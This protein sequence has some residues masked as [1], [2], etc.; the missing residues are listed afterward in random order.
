MI[1]EGPGATRHDDPLADWRL[2]REPFYMPV[3]DEVA[4]FD[5]AHR[6]RLPVLLKGPTGCG[7]TRFVEHM[8]WRLGK[9]LVTVACHDDLAASDLTGRWLLD[10]EGTRW[11]D[12]PLTLA[13]RHG[14]LCYLD[15]IVEARS[16]TTVVLHPL[17]DSRRLLPLEKRDEL[18]RAHADFQLV[19]SYNPGYRGISKSLKPSTRQRFM[20]L[21]FGYPDAEQEAAIVAREA[22]V[23]PGLALRLVVLAGRTRRLVDEGLD[24]GASTRMVIHAANL[25]RQGLGHR[26]ACRQAMV[27]PLSDDR[28]LLVAL[29]ATV[30]ATF[31]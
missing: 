27:L 7:K 14:A 4:A 12:G 19:V 23:E 22:Q 24:E 28:D 11:Q 2:G 16:D 26:V 25:I 17:A 21:E 9:P 30:D 31:G 5:A 8:A 29:Q 3:A 1:R 15:E 10:A 13:A 18:V 6:L 20:A